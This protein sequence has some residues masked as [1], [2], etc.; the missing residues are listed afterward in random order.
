[1]IAADNTAMEAVK[2]CW[3]GQDASKNCGRC[4]K[5]IRT[6]LNFLAVGVSRP[7][8]FQ[9][10]LDPRLITMMNFRNNAQF[11][12]VASVYSYAQRNGIKDQ[13]VKLLKSRINRYRNPPGKFRKFLLPIFKGFIAPKE[14]HRKAA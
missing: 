4:E 6:Q 10:P 5:C 12:E 14:H 3:E 1:L 7:P 8:C 2:V 13:W 9:G 11:N